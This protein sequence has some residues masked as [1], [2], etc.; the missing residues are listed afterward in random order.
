[1]KAVLNCHLGCYNFAL[2]INELAIQSYFHFELLK[3]NRTSFGG[4]CFEFA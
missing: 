3:I 4:G 2:K 1:M